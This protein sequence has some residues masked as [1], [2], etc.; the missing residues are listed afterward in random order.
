MCNVCR[1]RLWSYPHV[2]HGGRGVEEL[3]DDVG[4]GGDAE[5]DGAQ[6]FLPPWQQQH[7]VL[8]P[9][10]LAAR[11]VSLYH[12][13]GAVTPVAPSVGEVVAVVY[14]GEKKESVSEG[15]VHFVAVFSSP[16]PQY[17]VLTVWILE[18]GQRSVAV[19]IMGK[20]VVIQTLVEFV[21]ADQGRCPRRGICV[22]DK[23]SKSFDL[24]RESHQMSQHDS[25]RIVE[26]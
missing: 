7:G 13:H 9:A 15:S 22:K 17:E 12:A 1:L 19:L 6:D 21:R 2:G 4:G 26:H 16:C 24:S 18:D 10:S 25:Q 3:A 8:S 23:M 11:P 5:D 20:L 14:R